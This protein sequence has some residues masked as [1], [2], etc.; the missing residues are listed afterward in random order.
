[1][2]K[3]C[4]IVGIT[5]HNMRII[6]SDENMQMNTNYLKQMLQ[7]DELQG[8]IPFFIGATIGTTAST[9]IDPIAEIVEIKGDMWLHIDAALAGTALLCEEYREKWLTS[10]EFDTFNMNAHKWMLTNFDCSLLWTRNRSD[11]IDALTITPEYLR[12]KHSESGLVVD[13]RDWQIPLGRRFRSLKLWFVIRTY[14]L[15]G[16]RNYVRHVSENCSLFTV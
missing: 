9:S 6:P 14:G 7:N 1:M 3:A 10:L 16:L 8:F 4:H 11:L 5:E 2:K 12:N 15:T 13:Y